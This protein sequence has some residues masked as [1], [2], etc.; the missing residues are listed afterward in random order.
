MSLR[1]DGV[2][3]S[4]GAG[5]AIDDLEFRA[6]ALQ[7]DVVPFS[8]RDANPGG[9][10]FAFL[11][12]SWVDSD[13]SRTPLVTAVDATTGD[14]LLSAD[15]SSY[16]RIVFADRLNSG[17]QHFGKS[18]DF[19]FVPPPRSG[20][21]NTESAATLEIEYGS[22]QGTGTAAYRVGKGFSY[23]GSLAISNEVSMLSTVRLQH[24][25]AALG[26]TGIDGHSLIPTGLYDEPTNNALK[27]FASAAGI[28]VSAANIDL[29]QHPDVIDQLN[30]V[31]APQ[32]TNL[33]DYSIDNGA[34]FSL[35]PSLV[36]GG[37]GFA[38]HWI[39]E[40]V[41]KTARD[42]QVSGNS[43][44]VVVTR[45]QSVDGRPST[46]SGT[47]PQGLQL[48]IE[49]P[50]GSGTESAGQD[51]SSTES[52]IV[53]YL[54]QM[55][56]AETLGVQVRHV[57]IANQ[58]VVD[59]LNQAAGFL[60]ATHSTE[61]ADEAIVLLDPPPP[62][63]HT[64]AAAISGVVFADLNFDGH[65][66]DGEAPRAGARVYVDTNQNGRFDF[67]DIDADGIP[68]SGSEPWVQTNPY[69][70]FVFTNLTDL[71]Y[72]IGLA[73]GS[74]FALTTPLRGKGLQPG[75]ALYLG[76]GDYSSPEVD[77]VFAEAV[78]QIANQINSR[79]DDSGGELGSALTGLRGEDSA[80]GLRFSDVINP[81]QL[82]NNAVTNPLAALYRLDN[83]VTVDNIVAVL[84]GQF[85]QL[86]GLNLDVQVTA[87]DLAV[88]PLVDL[89]FAI[90]ASGTRD[91]FLDL[92]ADWQRA[93]LTIDSPPAV[94][95]DL[96]TDIRFRAQF[97]PHD[98]VESLLIEF[99][100]FDASIT[101]TVTDL[102]A[103]G[104]V[105]FADVAINGGQVAIDFEVAL[106]VSTASDGVIIPYRTWS[107]T[108]SSLEWSVDQTS[109]ISGTFP[110]T[111]TIGSF[112]SSAGMEFGFDVD[113]S[114]VTTSPSTT[115]I[116]ELIPLTLIDSTSVV[117]S[118]QQ[119]AQGLG[120]GVRSSVGDFVT[121]VSGLQSLQKSFS[122]ERALEMAF[123]GAISGVQLI[124]DA[125]P[126]ATVIET[127]IQATLTIDGDQHVAIIVVPETT[128]DNLTIDD[129]AV[130][131]E[132]SLAAGFDAIGVSTPAAEF[133]VI[134]GRLALTAIDN[135]IRDLTLEG[136]TSLGFAELQSEDGLPFDTI[137]EFRF[138]VAANLGVPT[139]SVVADYNPTTRQLRI[140][141]ADIRTILD[142]QVLPVSFDAS[143]SLLGR[144]E[145]DGELPVVSEL[146]ADLGLVFL[147]E[148]LGAQFDLTGATL[149][150]DL[151]A[152]Q[153]VVI[154]DDLDHHLKIELSSGD[155]FL[156][157]LRGSTTVDDVITKIELASD[158][159][160]G[161]YDPR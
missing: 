112:S 86:D 104:R 58:K 158:L 13:Q 82:F 10:E 84:T 147:L 80:A 1:I 116:D 146:D 118:L 78:L 92:G 108:P 153:G 67:V 77:P 37:F 152:G 64:V 143:G 156:V 154:E 15:G 51:L 7:G 103:E 109:M 128:A 100:S 28:D 126:T 21:L 160:G 88:N 16:G 76:E 135:G 26:Y 33:A 119:V 9:T 3:V 45:A 142:E 117:S 127:A 6:G 110:V 39:A 157:D 61:L 44:P 20:L 132:A 48:G 138:V 69:G 87:G 65:W 98:M 41:L 75:A 120:A 85:T 43:L 129:L 34:V 23:A 24:R 2:P 40:T 155:S 145:I 31:L 46:S 148:P 133:S 139:Q 29:R 93:G 96:T 123:L 81:V 52:G 56:Q 70:Q 55:I 159:P 18:G 71:S 106:G 25:L 79:L 101:K 62:T 97:D 99:E 17:S 130:D 144:F 35:S 95:L 141:I 14:L 72:D 83:L 137:D 57:E 42:L 107:E 124:A 66:D 102:A 91:V 38:S 161:S 131:L 60:V 50:P 63:H 111:S 68:D 121:P 12:L 134:N 22:T 47:L 11:G 89:Q 36:T 59:A 27:T 122:T 94:A 150:S 90:G 74:D 115:F 54:L 136:A 8:L 125:V 114:V 32:W 30:S 53:D 5:I 73:S 151:G 4:G 105:G 19:Y 113:G 49:I 149:L 140:E